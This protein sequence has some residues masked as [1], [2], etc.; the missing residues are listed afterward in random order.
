MTLSESTQEKEVINIGY[1]ET[2]KLGYMSD[3][4]LGYLEIASLDILGN[5]TF[6][7]P[8]AHLEP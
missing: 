2:Q 7:I 5:Y 8:K 1:T 6:P 4:E 3:K